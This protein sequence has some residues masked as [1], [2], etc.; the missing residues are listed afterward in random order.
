[1]RIEELPRA[2]LLFSCFS[3]HKVFSL[4]ETAL[5]QLTAR[6]NPRVKAA[7]RLCRDAKARRE[8]GTFFLEGARLCADAAQCGIAIETLFC[9]SGAA[10]KYADRLAAIL[11][12]AA[13][14]FEISDDLAA[15]LSDTKAP[16]GIFCI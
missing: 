12:R 14:A 3:F 2:S 4:E 11:P 16:Q 9:T 5:K 13:E 8:T 7:V 15:L 6:S 10:E 1:M